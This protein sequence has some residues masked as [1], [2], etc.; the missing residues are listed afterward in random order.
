M[1][2]KVLSLLF[3]VTDLDHGFR[4]EKVQSFRKTG[5][6]DLK[7]IKIYAGVSEIH[8]LKYMNLDYKD[9]VWKK[10]L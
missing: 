8:H 3:Q 9:K 10:Y 1:C 2:K 7:I 6:F 5:R 4:S